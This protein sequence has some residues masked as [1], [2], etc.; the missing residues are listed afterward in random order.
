[1]KH[2]YSFFDFVR[3]H[4]SVK[5]V[6]VLMIIVLIV[7]FVDE[8]SFYNRHQRMKEI[9]TLQEEIDMYRERYEEDTRK[10]KALEEYYNVE[11][12]A[13]EKYLMKRDNEDVFI[14]KRD[15]I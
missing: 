11:R 4:K 6:A 9:V 12:L 3:R 2:F 15:S 10:L 8:N 13:R 5:Y 14:I 1:M 7:G